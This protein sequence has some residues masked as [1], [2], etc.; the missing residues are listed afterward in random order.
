M[1]VCVYV[2]IRLQVGMTQRHPISDGGV[3]QY[4]AVCCSVLQRIAEWE[5]ILLGRNSHDPPLST[6]RRQCDA[7][8]CS[9]LQ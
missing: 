6:L 5:C 3:W 9:M 1:Y 2:C 7:V 8:C 4:V